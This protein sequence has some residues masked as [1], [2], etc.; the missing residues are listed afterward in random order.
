MT[1]AMLALLSLD[2]VS[3]ARYNVM[4]PF[5]ISAVLL[6]IHAAR[7]SRRKVIHGYSITVL[8]LNFIYYLIRLSLGLF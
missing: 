7:F 2:V 8:I 1:R 3:Y 6:E 5:V 4:A